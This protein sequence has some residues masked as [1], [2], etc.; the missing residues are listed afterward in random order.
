MIVCEAFHPPQGCAGGAPYSRHLESHAAAWSAVQT[1]PTPAPCPIQTRW[2][3]GDRKG[4]RMSARVTARR[5]TTQKISEWRWLDPNDA[6][7]SLHTRKHLTTHVQ[8]QTLPLLRVIVCSHV[9]SILWH[10]LVQRTRRHATHCH[11]THCQA[12]RIAQRSEVPC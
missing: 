7:S 3:V 8:N 1:W 11:A 9:A 10:S 4:V 12:T 5:H 6:I 2:D